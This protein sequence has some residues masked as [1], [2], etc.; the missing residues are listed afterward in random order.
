MFSGM[1]FQTSHSFS[2]PLSPKYNFLILKGLRDN[3][4]N[5]EEKQK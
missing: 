3:D 2:L 5:L 1:K 4:L